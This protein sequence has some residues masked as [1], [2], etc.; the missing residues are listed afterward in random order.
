M[1]SCSPRL[2]QSEALTEAKKTSHL[3]AQTLQNSINWTMQAQ[4]RH[5]NNNNNNNN[6][7]NTAAPS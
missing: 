3:M 4:G 6:N 5:N 1:V 7:K 2:L